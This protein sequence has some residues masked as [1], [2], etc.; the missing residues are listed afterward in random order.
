MKEG[1]GLL[2]RCVLLVW[3]LELFS[4]RG[5]FC[6]G[7][8]QAGLIE[9]AKKEGKAVFYATLNINDRNALRKS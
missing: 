5:A 2:R 7:P 1:R 3:L 9:A 6:Q 8:G 4:W